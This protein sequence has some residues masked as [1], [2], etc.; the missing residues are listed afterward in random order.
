MRD[1]AISISVMLVQEVS[2][3]NGKSNKEKLSTSYY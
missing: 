3:G 1:T 2:Q